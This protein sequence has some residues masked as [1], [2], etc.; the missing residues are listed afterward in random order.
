MSGDLNEPGAIDPA[1]DEDA[2]AAAAADGFNP[3][4]RRIASGEQSNMLLLLLQRIFCGS[5]LAFSGVLTVD[6]LNLLFSR[7][8]L[9]NH[10]LVNCKA[11]ASSPLNS[12][13]SIST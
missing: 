3:T 4:H 8:I 2:E 11:D 10:L 9:R 7:H 5:E 6:G 1:V 12:H 13:G